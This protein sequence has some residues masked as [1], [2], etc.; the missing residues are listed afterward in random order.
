MSVGVRPYRRGRW[1]VD[2]RLVLPDGTRFRERTV[3]KTASKSGAQRWGQERERHLLR[4]GPPQHT[5]EVP[6]LEAFAPCQISPGGGQSFSPDRGPFQRCHACRS[7]VSYSFFVTLTMRPVEPVGGPLFS[8]VQ[9]P[10]GNSFCEFS[11]ASATC[12]GSSWK[13]A[14]RWLPK[15]A[16]SSS[17]WARSSGT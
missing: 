2:I 1:H 15:S 12:C 17:R 8:A 11:T 6:T 9:G 14:K 5:K 7:P 13:R 10:V 4:S 3:F 16:N